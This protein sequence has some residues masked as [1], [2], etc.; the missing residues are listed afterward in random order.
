MPALA[1]FD[2]A[3]PRVECAPK[4]LFTPADVKHCLIHLAI[5]DES[6]DLCGRFNE[7]KSLSQCCWRKDAVRS[8]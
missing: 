4:S 1:A 2:A 8:T 5:V 3:E 6:I 7:I